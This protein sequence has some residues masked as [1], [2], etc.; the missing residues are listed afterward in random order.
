MNKKNLIRCNI[1]HTKFKNGKKI[2][3]KDLIGLGDYSQ[4]ICQCPNCG[5][6]FVKNPLTQEQLDEKYKKFSKY[7]F[8]NK[9]V[10]IS[11]T[12]MNRCI[13]Q[14]SFI[15]NS[16]YANDESFNSILEIGAASGANLSLYKEK[17]T[18]GVEPSK[19]NC[20]N[21]KKN[22]CVEMFAG[23]FDEYI[24]TYSQ[25]K[26]D[27][28]F[29]SHTLEHIV[30]P[31][32]F[33]KQ[34]SKINEKYFFI[35]VPSF[36]YK[37]KDEPYGM[38][39]D[40]HVNMFTFES[41]QILMNVCGYEILNAEIPFD[42]CNVLPSGFP[43]LRTLWRKSNNPKKYETVL[44]SKVLFKEYIEWSTKEQK[45]LK[46][47]I[48]GIPSTAK[49]A[50]WGIGNTASRLIGSTKLGK[51]NIVKCYDS[52][53]RKHGLLF[54][55]IKVCAFNEEDIKNGIIDTVVITTCNAQNTLIGILKPYN[56]NVVKLFNV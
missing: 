45:T 1:C 23:T 28:I 6:I 4:E 8:D 30:N 2:L 7:E 27:M 18:F 24:Q 19:W 52:D 56:V 44:S 39:T 26:Y 9:D 36:D 31:C 16:L 33:I 12:Y 25:K 55:G 51:K 40:E 22:Y 29:L 43:S 11:K 13:E 3:F 47:K 34:C 14:K 20:E 35:E 41:L 49:V 21:A 32:A 17:N 37:L 46:R 50:L 10:S 15:E 5:F 38:F 53:K 54:Q 48:D 42:T